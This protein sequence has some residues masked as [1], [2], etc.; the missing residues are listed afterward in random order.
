MRADRLVTILLMFQS[1]GR[2]TAPRLARELE[3]SERT[4]L[5]DIEALETAGV[6]IISVRGPQGGFEL[7]EGFRTQLTGLRDDEAAALS[8]LGPPGAAELLGM[9]PALARARLK[10]GQARSPEANGAADSF[11]GRFHHHP[12]PW[13]GE[14]PKDELRFLQTAITRQREV[15]AKTS[16][17]AAGAATLRPLGLVLK[18]GDWYLVAEIASAVAAFP[19]GELLDLTTTGRRFERPDRFDLAAFWERWLAAG[20]VGEGSPPP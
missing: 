4:V 13:S 6:P 11:A 14:A 19:V 7:I 3:V 2:L 16:A 18:A 5:R 17:A 15:S 8:L 10:L 1:R 9:G 20:P 12:R